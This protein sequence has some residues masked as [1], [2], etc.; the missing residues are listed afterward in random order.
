MIL[1]MDKGMIV[2]EGTHM[3][4]MEKDEGLYKGLSELQFTM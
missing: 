2:E 4:L 1:V 3:E